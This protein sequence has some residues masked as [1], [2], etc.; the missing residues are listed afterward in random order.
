MSDEYFEGWEPTH[1]HMLE[2]TFVLAPGESFLVKTGIHMKIPE[3]FY[4]DLDTRSSTSKLK[5]DLLCHTIDNDYLGN[6]RLALINLNSEPVTLKNGQALA[7]I[8]I[9]SYEKGKPSKLDN[10]E[11]FLFEAGET[12][13]GANGFGHTGRNV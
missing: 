7:Q 3:G 6:I 9:K 13:R 11:D 1:E 5:L 4:G 10:L 2:G 12:T 8:I